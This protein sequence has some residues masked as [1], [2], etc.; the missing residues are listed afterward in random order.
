MGHRVNGWMY[1]AVFGKSAGVGV[2]AEALLRN[3][4]MKAIIWKAS[5]WQV[6]C[7]I[8]PPPRMGEIRGLVWCCTRCITQVWAGGWIR[9][10]VSDLP[11]NKDLSLRYNS[12]GLMSV[13][14]F[15]SCEA[16]EVPPEA[17]GLKIV[18]GTY[19][20][21]CDLWPA[22]SSKSRLGVQ[23]GRCPV[24]LQRVDPWSPL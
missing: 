7:C 16:W 22:E 20:V 3:D 11:G 4:E 2:H 23:S 18:F 14:L 8:T 10:L 6:P 24:L 17:L 1:S 15:R 21:C 5:A 12:K 19:L 9:V 13:R